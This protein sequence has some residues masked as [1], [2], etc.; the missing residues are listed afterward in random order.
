M[1]PT[2]RRGE[3]VRVRRVPVA[4]LQAGD[5]VLFEIPGDAVELHRIVVRLPRGV[6]VHRGD[7]VSARTGLVR[8][9][10]VIGR[11]DLPPRPPT[12]RAVARALAT[13]AVERLSRRRRS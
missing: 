6:L 3:Q 9:G 2:L 7:A 5:V 11:A 1:E 10:R 13:I 12:V 4:A 8:E